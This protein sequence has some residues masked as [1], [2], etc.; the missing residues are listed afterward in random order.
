MSFSIHPLEFTELSLWNIRRT[1]WLGCLS[2]ILVVSYARYFTYSG[3]ILL[4]FWFVKSNAQRVL[5]RYIK[6]GWRFLFLLKTSIFCW[7]FV[8][9]LW[10]FDTIAIAIWKI[11]A[12]ILCIFFFRWLKLTGKSR[13]SII[14]SFFI[15]SFTGYL[16]FFELFKRNGRINVNIGKTRIINISRMISMMFNWLFSFI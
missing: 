12:H 2:S 3:R 1:T 16:C 4:F 7:C 10:F 8:L 13:F 11:R 15:K 5:W 9:L 6:F 14:I